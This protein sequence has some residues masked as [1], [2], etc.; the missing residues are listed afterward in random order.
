[1]EIMK[2]LLQRLTLCGLL[3]FCG[4]AG[5]AQSTEYFNNPYIVDQSGNTLMFKSAKTEWLQNDTL[6]KMK[7]DYHYQ[8]DKIEKIKVYIELTASFNDKI[9]ASFIDTLQGIDYYISIKGFNF[10]ELCF[11]NIDQD[12]EKEVAFIFE[13]TPLNFESPSINYALVYDHP[14][15]TI[16]SKN[17]QP[18]K[19]VNF[20]EDFRI[21]FKHF[22]IEEQLLHFAKIIYLENDFDIFMRERLLIKG[23]MASVS[24]DECLYYFHYEG[25]FLLKFKIIN[26]SKETI[27]I[28]LKNQQKIY[29][30]QWGIQ[31]NSEIM[32]G[33]EK[34]RRLNDV[35]P[36]EINAKYE[37]GELTF[38]RPN[39]ELI[40]YI[41][42]QKPSNQP[43]AKS[44]E[45]FL[46]MHFDGQL[47]VSNGKETEILKFEQENESNRVFIFNNPLI[48][49][50]LP[51]R[52][53]IFDN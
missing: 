41:E 35:N 25:N 36:T 9:L 29:L 49:K 22:T 23:N 48:V 8:S 44:P 19:K 32:I 26:T 40:Y 7:L 47:V 18:L 13:L 12:H 15:T 33:N 6:Y 27:G 11:V 45:D 5:N 50:L 24:F 2:N 31:K 28:D 16:A 21:D 14:S 42:W 51:K 52:I 34:R 1:M 37:K 3:L 39:Q 43:S 20:D 17:F 53:L 46:I 10:S 30:N 38:L 4:L